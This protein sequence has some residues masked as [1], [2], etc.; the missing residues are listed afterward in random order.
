MGATSSEL[1]IEL[2]KLGCISLRVGWFVARLNVLSTPW[3]DVAYL[4]P[5][6]VVAVTPGSLP[7]LSTR[8]AS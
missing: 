4:F 7:C 6:V 5:C 1:L 2:Y 8:G 3:R